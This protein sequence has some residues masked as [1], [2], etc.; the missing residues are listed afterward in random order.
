[1]IPRPFEVSSLIT[2]IRGGHIVAFDGEEHRILRD[3][4]VVIEEDKVKFVGRSYSDPVD[5]R[6]DASKSLV[7]PGFVCLHSHVCG[8]HGETGKRGD[9]SRR[10]LYNSDLFDRMLPRTKESARAA[11][12]LNYI[13]VLKSGC[14]TLVELGSPNSLGNKEAVDLANQMGIRAYLIR[15]YRSGHWY[16]PDGKRVLY[17]N[18]DGERWDEEPGFK[19]LEECINF[20]QEYD[21]AADGRIRCL[22]GPSTVDACSRELLKESRRKADELSIGLQTHVSQSVVEFHEIM[23][24]YGMTPIEFLK[25]VGLLGSDLIAGH[26]ILIGGHSKIGYADPWRRDLA[27]LATTGTSVAHCPLVFSRYGIAMESYARYLMEGV[28]VGIGTDTYPLDIIREMG[29]AATISKIIEGEPRV[30]TSRDVFNSV[31]LSGSHA[32]RRTDIGRI[33]PG[34]KADITIIKLNSINMSPVRDPIRNLVMSGTNND[35]TTVII[36]GQ[37]VV[38]EGIVPGIDE[39]KLAEDLQEEQEKIWDMLPSYDIFGR[40]IDKMTSPSFK[41]WSET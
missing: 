28:N 41:E 21:G 25:D 9:G 18:F 31:T 40:T 4:V 5:R 19:E 10:Q 39:E 13:E 29:L 8:G 22:L 33:A 3:G 30:A 36:D 12:H 37:L 6:I 16:T 24:R 38:E 7:T 14:T 35:V 32:L 26:C 15:N 17:E 27:L 1:V 20:I 34:A 11:A 2:E 23:R